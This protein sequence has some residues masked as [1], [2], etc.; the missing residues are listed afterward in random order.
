MHSDDILSTFY[1][2]CAIFRYGSLVWYGLGVSSRL[3]A[4]TCVFVWFR[5]FYSVVCYRL[6]GGEG[7]CYNLCDR[8]PLLS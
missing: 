8:L 5:N 3:V 1:V 7:N 6:I 4:S 2:Y